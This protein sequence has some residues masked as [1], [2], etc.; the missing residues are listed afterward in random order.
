MKAKKHKI[1]KSKKAVKLKKIK[2]SKLAKP[3]ISKNTTFME[4]MQ[5]YP[6]SAEILMNRG[7]HCIGCNMA[8]FETIEQGAMMHGLD[9]EEIIN[10]INK[11]IN[12]KS[13]G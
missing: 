7:M 12:R 6:E 8:G 5:K 3:K 11:K 9:S 10:E 13:K 1:T 2:K 4:L